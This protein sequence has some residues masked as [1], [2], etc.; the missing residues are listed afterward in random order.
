MH[1]RFL[2][3]EEKRKMKETDE[4][5]RLAIIYEAR[6]GNLYDDQHVMNDGGVG[7]FEQ[8][9]KENKLEFVINIVNEGFYKPGF[10]ML[11]FGGCRK[12]ISSLII[13]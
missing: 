1:E 2:R 11:I 7:R 3:P 9:N 10:K 4:E 6:D 13:H 12:I 5:L 8:K